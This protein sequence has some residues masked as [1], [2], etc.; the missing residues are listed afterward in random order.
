MA[1]DVKRLADVAPTVPTLTQLAS[2]L[3]NNAKPALTGTG[4]AGSL[5]TIMDGT[6][7]L[8]TTTVGNDG[9]WTYTPATA[10]ADGVHQLSVKA[11]SS[12]NSTVFSAAT[13]A[14]AYTVDT[15]PPAA[16]VISTKTGLTNNGKISLAGTTEGGATIKIMDAGVLIATITANSKGAWAY[17]P[18][19]AYK[20][21]THSFTVTATDAAGN[22]SPV[23][24]ALAMTID[25]IGPDAPTVTTA[26]L[27]TN[28][29]KPIVTGTAEAKSTVKIYDNGTAIGTVVADA[30]G[31]WT[32]TP[33][34]ALTEG[35]HT[36]TARAT[37]AAGNMSVAS[38]ALNMVTTSKIISSW[39][40]MEAIAGL[41]GK[42]MSIRDRA[43][44]LA[45]DKIWAE[46]IAPT[47]DFSK[48]GVIKAD[49]VL[50]PQD[51]IGGLSAADSVT[52]KDVSIYNRLGFGAKAFVFPNSDASSHKFNGALIW[53]DASDPTTSSLMVQNF[54]F[55]NFTSATDAGKIT[56]LDQPRAVADIFDSTHAP[57]SSLSWD[58]S[59]NGFYLQW[60]QMLADKSGFVVN[61]ITFDASGSITSGPTATDTVFSPTTRWAS[62]YDPLGNLDLVSID[63]TAATPT[64]NILRTGADGTIS[65]YTFTPNFT[66]NNLANTGWSFSWNYTN[67]EASGNYLTTEFAVEGMRDGKYYMDFY[68][69]DTDFKI[70]NT[71]SV[72]LNAAISPGGRI[73]TLA[74]NNGTY[75]LFYYQ[76]GTNIHLTAIDGKGAIIQDYIQ[77]VAAGTV[78][79]N[80]KSMGDGRFEISLIT[81]GATG[82]NSFGTLT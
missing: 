15:K 67:R 2:T 28:N 29:F 61:T 10:L 13:T 17:A 24:A 68:Q 66:T 6:K 70:L 49:I 73:Q 3:S 41:D 8:G 35:G 45:G 47:A 62:K 4:A 1:V 19:T 38:S 46:T 23:S 77:T 22:V 52:I 26:S 25:T 59:T 32:F 58:V 44:D 14:F 21:G 48:A 27:L 18:T 55:N 39:G 5:I 33:G 72:Q 7:V 42:T 31:K 43:S 69:T 74:M 16:P 53:I 71:S 37:D 80:L 60:D 65:T 36:I 9:K 20:D 40:G 57:N 79:D 11:S 78:I 12:A 75:N 34:T 63:P 64:Y 54:T 30:T 81:K 76:D 56:L 82:S 50:L 51:R